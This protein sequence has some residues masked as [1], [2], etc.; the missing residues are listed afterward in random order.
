MV[1]GRFDAIAEANGALPRC[2]TMP[3]EARLRAKIFIAV[4]D[5]DEDSRVSITS[6]I[7][8]VDFATMDCPNERPRLPGRV[9]QSEQFHSNRPHDWPRQCSNVGQGNGAPRC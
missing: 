6:L 7:E 9:G 1:I 8:S 4:I 3:A 5:D 2:S